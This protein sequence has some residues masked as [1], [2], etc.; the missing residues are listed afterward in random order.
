[1][2]KFLIAG[3][4][5]TLIAVAETELFFVRDVLAAF[6]VFCIFLSALGIA[7]LLLYLIGDGVVRCSRHLMVCAASFRLREPVRSVV[8]HLAHRTG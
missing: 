1:M 2:Q 5:I 4:L 6:L 8:G 7:I 3:G